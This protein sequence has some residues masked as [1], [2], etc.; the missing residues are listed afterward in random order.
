MRREV[1]ARRGSAGLD[2]GDAAVI[3]V[4][5]MAKEADKKKAK[6]EAA[7]VP[8]VK[9]AKVKAKNETAEKK[10]KVEAAKDAAACAAGSGPRTKTT[11]H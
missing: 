9:A 3:K 5:D 4:K 1:I 8:K 7:V 10:A 2:G 6:E 11:T